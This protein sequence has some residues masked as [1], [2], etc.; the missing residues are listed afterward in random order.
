MSLPANWT[1]GGAEFH[2]SNENA[3]ET[4]VNTNT[5]A[6]ASLS[7][8]AI[9]ARTVSVITTTTTLANTTNSDVVAIIG[10][11]GAPT[12]PTAASNKNRYT[13]KNSTAGNITVA[14]TG[15][16]TIEGSTLPITLTAYAAIELVSDGTSN[17]NII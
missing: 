13:V 17:W 5:A 4:Q 3:V 9:V 14:A 6:I 10:G 2:A 15:S 11:G 12:L 8:T 1:D 7:A 16:Q